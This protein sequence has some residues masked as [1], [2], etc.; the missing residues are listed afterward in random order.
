MR[1]FKF[2]IS[3]FFLGATMAAQANDYP[4]ADRVQYV[5]GCMSDLGESSIDNL[6]TCSCRIDAIAAMLSFDEYNYGTAFRR[7]RPMPGEKGGIFRDS[8]PGKAAVQRLEEVEEAVATK[9]KKVI[10]IKA[11]T[12]SNEE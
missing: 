12:P 2:L 5:L 6:N 3:V 7:N 1:M 4:T 10:R 9:C 8:K 11:P